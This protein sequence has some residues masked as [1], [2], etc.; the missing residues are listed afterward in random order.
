LHTAEELR[1]AQERLSEQAR[2]KLERVLSDAMAFAA[3]SVEVSG[4]ADVPVDLGKQVEEALAD[5]WRKTVIASGEIVQEAVKSTPGYEV[6]NES[7]WEKVLRDF[8]EQYGAAAV[9]AIAETTADQMRRI[10]ASGIKEGL[11]IREIAKQIREAIPELSRIRSEVIARTET[12]T[13]SGYASHETAKRSR[14]TLRRVWVSVED[15]RTRD[16]GEGDGVIDE[17]SHRAMNGIEVGM[18]EPF[19]VPMRTGGTEAV[20]YP[21][22]PNASPGNRIGCRCGATYRKERGRR[23][24]RR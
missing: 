7:F 12:H 6:K 5:L 22:D 20:M 11:G 8:I 24:P 1:A 10:L 4:T 16:F 9:R 14:I 18:D 19:R 15:A 13:A 21:G 2:F 3:R 23:K 17:F